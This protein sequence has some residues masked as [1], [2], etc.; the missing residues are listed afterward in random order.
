MQGFCTFLMNSVRTHFHE[1][2]LHTRIDHFIQI[3]VD[4]YGIG[5]G[6][7]RFVFHIINHDFYRGQQ[8]HFKACFFVQLIQQRSDCR[9]AVGSGN[10][11]QFQFF[12]RISIIIGGHVSQGFIGIFYLDISD[13]GYK[14]FRQ[15]IANNGNGTQLNGFPYIIVPI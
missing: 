13:S 8:S 15:S 14:I 3:M 4:G 10:T 11:H 12:G 1:T 6:V 2:I 5:R 7:G 9:F